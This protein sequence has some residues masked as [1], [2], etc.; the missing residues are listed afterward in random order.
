MPGNL[1]VR[2]VRYLA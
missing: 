1:Q 2:E